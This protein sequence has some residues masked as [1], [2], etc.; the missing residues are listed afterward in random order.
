MNSLQN[1][2][3]VSDTKDESGIATFIAKHTDILNFGLGLFIG[4]MVVNTA[5]VLSNTTMTALGTAT[6]MVTKGIVNMLG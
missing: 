1:T 6:Y 3:K 2:E 5:D 4:L